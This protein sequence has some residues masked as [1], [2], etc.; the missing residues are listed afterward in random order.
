ME[1]KILNAV[2]TSAIIDDGGIGL[3]TAWIHVDH[4][5]GSQGFGMHFTCQ[6][7]LKMEGEVSSGYA[8]HFIF[9]C[10]QIAG[11]SEWSKMVGKT[12][13]VDAEHSKIHGICHIVKNDWFYPSVD[14]N[15]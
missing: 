7:T 15:N 5:N 13:R 10:M 6:K 2:I 14:F 3:L 8:G 9:R 11:V 12:I 4:E 1:R